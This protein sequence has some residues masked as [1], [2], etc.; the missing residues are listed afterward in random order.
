MDYGA[1]KELSTVLMREIKIFA[2]DVHDERAASVEYE[3]WNNLT[4]ALSRTRWS[5]SEEMAI[6][7]I[8]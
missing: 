2:L 4:C 3:V 6:L 7:I 1:I 8:L 5:D